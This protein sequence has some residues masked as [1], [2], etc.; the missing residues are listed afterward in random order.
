[1]SW[2]DDHAPRP[3]WRIWGRSPYHT[4]TSEE[5]HDKL[6][7][8]RDAARGNL[9]TMETDIATLRA[10]AVRKRATGAVNPAALDLQAAATLEERMKSIHKHVIDME[11]AWQQMQI[12]RA[13]T[14]R[15][16][17]WRLI[18]ELAVRALSDTPTDTVDEE[19]DETR[20][21]MYD[22]Q[23]RSRELEGGSVVPGRLVV[24]DDDE[25]VADHSRTLLLA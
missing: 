10:E 17:S 6:Q 24:L 9:Q 5:L 23:E 12:A 3:L 16:E 15:L 14:A 18:R 20:D 1:M 13:S 4:F 22:L 8:L 25:D 7:D 2:C 19:R 21:T 11:Y